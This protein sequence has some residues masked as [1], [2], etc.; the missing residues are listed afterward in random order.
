[1]SVSGQRPSSGRG[2]PTQPRRGGKGAARQPN[3]AQIRAMEAR[4]E[5]T[6]AA[7]AAA[8]TGD[9]AAPTREEGAPVAA[10]VRDTP[11]G[12]GRVVARPVAISREEEYAY[13][14][15]DLNRLLVTA[16]ALLVLMIALL[17]LVEG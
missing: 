12:R 2:T 1:M 17:F 13:I 4:A 7:R 16:G 11:R 9:L 6:R 10:R 5:A 8:R 14:R 3:R 15:A